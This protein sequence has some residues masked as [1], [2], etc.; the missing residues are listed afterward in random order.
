[1]DYEIRAQWESEAGVWVAA[2]DDVPGLWQ[3]PIPPMCW[4]KN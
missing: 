4:R 1:M 3:R 2:S